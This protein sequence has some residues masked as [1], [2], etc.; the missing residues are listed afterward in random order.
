MNAHPMAPR[1]S[2]LS[3]PFWQAARAGV[4]VLQRC[5]TCGRWEWTPQMACSACHT[6][7]LD[8]QEAS[9][10]GTLYSFSVVTRPQTP[11]FATPYV[12]AIV[13]LAEGPRMLT[14]LVGADTD[15]ARG[16]LAIG[17]PVE[18]AFT[19]DGLYHFRAVTR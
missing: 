1:P 14:D 18:V 4:L 15:S 8:W 9:G 10:R 17:M 19:G 2:P 16:N 11:D 6:E 5:R 12:V 7:T 3:E 13:E